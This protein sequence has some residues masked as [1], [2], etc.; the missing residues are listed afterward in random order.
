MSRLGEFI[1]LGPFNLPRLIYAQWRKQD[2]YVSP[3]C[4]DE[5]KYTLARLIP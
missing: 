2:N 5:T 1:L 4:Y 3:S